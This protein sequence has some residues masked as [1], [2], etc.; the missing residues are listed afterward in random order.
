MRI[1]RFY[2][3]DLNAVDEVVKL[4]TDAHR[5]AVQVLRL[6]T[7]AT[8]RLFDGAGLEYEASLHEVSKRESTAI[9]STTVSNNNESNLSLT[10]IQG[11]SRGER[12]DYTLQKA[13][14]LGVN[15]IVPVVTER[16]NVQLSGQRAD[17]KLAHWQG[18]IIS[19]CE[20]SG[21]RTMPVLDNIISFDEM[22]SEFDSGSRLILEPT[23][24]I[25]FKRLP[26]Q[27]ETSLVIGPEGGFS[28]SEVEEA[29]N[30]G[31]QAI[32]FGPRILRTETAAVSALA[33][34]QTLWG[35]LG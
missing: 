18:V 15:R 4:P 27:T 10:L 1:P 19:A 9:L 33:V 7:G 21:R 6:K 23:A 29:I 32:Q 8:V 14:E 20:Q 35:D 28:E 34:L 25:G 5:H 17:K 22:L 2:C 31:F 16:C 3:S 30:N 11:I 12:M 26:P 13:V 24:E